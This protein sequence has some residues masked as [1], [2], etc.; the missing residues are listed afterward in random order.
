MKYKFLV[1][2]CT[3]NKPV[4]DKIKDKQ[5][6]DLTKMMTRSRHASN[7][8]ENEKKPIQPQIVSAKPA[9]IVE[10]DT[11]SICFEN[12]EPKQPKKT[13]HSGAGWSHTFHGECIDNWYVVCIGEARTPCCPLCPDREFPSN[14]SVS[15]YNTRK[16][17]ATELFQQ[18]RMNESLCPYIGIMVCM[19]GDLKYKMTNLDLC[20]L[21]SDIEYNIEYNHEFTLRDIKE[22]VLELEEPLYERFGNPNETRA[23]K[24][25]HWFYGTHPKLKI[26]YDSYIIPPRRVSFGEMDMS[27]LSDDTTLRQMYID[28]HT[29]LEALKHNP[30]VVSDSLSVL[31]SNISTEQRFLKD[32]Y[33]NTGY[34][35]PENPRV[36]RSTM[37][38]WAWI[39]IHCEWEPQK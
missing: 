1:Y 15:T 33:W 16:A 30:N 32:G 21:S 20:I 29:Q 31:I 24:L 37:F 27:N 23:Q 3:I 28:Y 9:Q 7:K 17:V 2:V 18:I 34:L 22:K 26:T 14:Y 19:N 36:I 10:T 4:I 11:C 8:N 38:P 25:S 35:N 5:L 13:L 39:T 12:I 6:R